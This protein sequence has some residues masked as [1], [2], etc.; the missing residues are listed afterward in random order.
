MFSMICDIHL[1][2]RSVPPALSGRNLSR[3]INNNTLGNDMMPLDFYRPIKEFGIHPF[4]GTASILL[5][6]SGLVGA[7]YLDLSESEPLR[8]VRTRRPELS[9]TILI[10]TNIIR[11][12]TEYRATRYVIR[13]VDLR[14]LMSLA[15]SHGVADVTH[16]THQLTN[17]PSELAKFEDLTGSSRFTVR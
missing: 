3:P 17:R 9:R 6:R 10:R 8:I 12:P 15:C 13:L 4:A 5:L 16:F 7:P 11:C 2:R 1:N 14:G